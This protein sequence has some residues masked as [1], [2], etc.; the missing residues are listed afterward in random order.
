MAEKRKDKGSAD[1]DYKARQAQQQTMK[2]IKTFI[3]V[4]LLGLAVGFAYVKK[5]TLMAMLSKPEPPPAAPMPKPAPVAKVE[6]TIEAP[7]PPIAKP[8]APAEKP[9]VELAAPPQALRGTDD[10]AAKALLAQGREL[11]EKFE[12]DKAGAVF[13]EAGLKKL[14]A[15]V[16]AEAGT[17]EKK[18]AAFNIAT[19]HIPVSEFATAD[20]AVSLETTDG[21]EMV[22]LVK[23]E[24]GGMI[25]FQM[26][27]NPVSPGKT[28]LPLPVSDIKKK[29]PL[30][31]KQ[32]R[33]QFLELLGGLESGMQI[34]R[35]TD[36]YDLVY[37]SK[38]LG[39]GRECIE[40]LNRAYNGGPG[41][42]ADPYLADS[43]RKE[44]IRRT[45]DKCSLMLAG[46]RA[47]RFAEDELGK[48][49][50]L[51]PGYEV[52]DDEVS[53][54][55]MNVM[56]KI[57]S[58]FKS[59]IRISDAKPKVAVTV[60]KKGQA[61]VQSARE[62]AN[63]D[64]MEFVVENGGVT[65]KGAAGPVVE[66]A[67]AKYEEGMKVYR[68]YRQG[69]NG[70]NNKVLETAMHLLESAVDLYDKALKTD[71]SNKAVLDRQTEANMI[72]YACKKYH[73]L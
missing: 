5:D 45:I 47:K 28:T 2:T 6:K 7:P 32:R 64:Q 60:A 72:V 8:A 36:Y 18:A 37:I 43:F 26:V 50:K 51:F 12:F 62:I 21:R 68:T 22:G 40:Y 67:N 14:S 73:T 54:F 44:V 53:A 23:S 38:R 49:L 3:F 13:K 20:N 10:E 42:K 4:I 33:E 70:A 16:K 59:T 52:A 17:W 63:E 30:S 29:T 25:N 15:N 1:S 41:H 69:T 57:A 34:E 61:P 56:S 48:L 66:Q 35:G 11:L 27:L 58:D 39:L 46:G 65:G 9:K 55:K 24:S 31:L 71:P 19:K